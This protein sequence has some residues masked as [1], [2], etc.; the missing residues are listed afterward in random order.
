[1][2]K[3][4]VRKRILI[5]VYIIIPFFSFSQT[6]IEK[7]SLPELII[8][9]SN[10]V[11]ILDSFLIQEPLHYNH[12]TVFLFIDVCN[13]SWKVDEKCSIEDTMVVEIN[14]TIDKS[15]LFLTEKEGFIIYKNTYGTVQG[16]LMPS[17]FNETD[18]R[19]IFE[20]EKEMSPANMIISCKDFAWYFYYI[21]GEFIY[22]NEP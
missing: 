10:F 20:Y 19:K 5:L 11:N 15:L 14:S 6:T 13:Y 17:L 7:V 12:D 9:D 18:I 22:M 21:N 3:E 1:M 4:G 16:I 2:G 8:Q